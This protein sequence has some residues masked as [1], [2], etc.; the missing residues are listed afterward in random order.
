LLA[1]WQELN[2]KYGG[3]KMKR[4]VFVSFDEFCNKI[5]KTNFST[6]LIAE[7]VEEMMMEKKELKKK[8]KQRKDKKGKQKSPAG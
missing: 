6:E 5:E 3:E 4:V 7:A 2:L 1:S 8:P